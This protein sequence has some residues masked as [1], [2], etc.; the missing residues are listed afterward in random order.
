MFDKNAN[1]YRNVR[2]FINTDMSYLPQAALQGWVL[3]VNLILLLLS[4]FCIIMHVF[5]PLENF[6]YGNFFQKWINMRLFM[7]IYSTTPPFCCMPQS[8]ISTIL[9]PQSLIVAWGGV[10][11]MLV[12]VTSVSNPLICFSPI[13]VC[14]DISWSSIRCLVTWAMSSFKGGWWHAYSI[15]CKYAPQV[16][17]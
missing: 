17:L 15:L 1:I 8:P 3:H 11:P 2:I 9:S 13:A 5:H 14:K 7:Y 10:T 6:S 4:Y 16:L 12:Q